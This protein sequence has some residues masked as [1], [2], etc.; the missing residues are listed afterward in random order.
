MPR[1]E[2]TNGM[3]LEHEI[4]E[5]RPRH[6]FNIARMKDDFARRT[7]LVRVIDDDGAEG[8]GEAPVSTPYYGE[9]ADTVVAVLPVLWKAASSF[10]LRASSD[11]SEAIDAVERAMDRAIGYNRGAKA[12]ISAALHDLAGKRAGRPVWRTWGLDPARTPRSSFTIAIDEPAVMGQRAREAAS[13]PILKIKVGTDQDEAML[14]AIRDAAPHASIKVDANTAWTVEQTLAK[15][16]MLEELGVELIEQPLDPDDLEGYARLRGRSRIPIYADESCRTLDD[17]HRL[18]GKVDG[19]NIKL[20]KCG[21][22]LEARRMV[23]AA[24]GYGMGVMLGCMVE[25]T[26]GIAAGVQLAPLMDHLDLDGA[27]LLADDPIA[28]PGVGPDGSVRFNDEPGLG[29]RRR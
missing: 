29:V 25:T 5:L 26:L 12:A 22:L 27:L 13:F 6:A 16:P 11:D 9:T 1:Q 23:E 18:A 15:L 21:S 17:V 8:W 4:L 7:V 28:G 2:P 19:I 20:A 3:R 24:R 10:E 14:R